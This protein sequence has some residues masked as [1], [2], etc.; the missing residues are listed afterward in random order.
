MH[1]ILL[2]AP[3]TGKGTQAK[4][5]AEKKGWLHISTGDMLREAVANKTILG[6]DPG[7]AYFIAENQR[8]STASSSSVNSYA[9]GPA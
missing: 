8:H 2:G 6:E 5:L 3:G 7:K 4:L 9:P 1:L